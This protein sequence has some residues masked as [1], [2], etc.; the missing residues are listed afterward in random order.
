MKKIKYLTLGIC[1]AVVCS[2]STKA[3]TGSI[4]GAG[5]GAVIGGILGNIIGKD[6]KATVIGAAIGSAVGAGSG[7]LIGKHMD[8]VAAETAAQVENA[9]VET[10][11]DANGLS[12]VK[13]TFDSGILFKT[14]KYD[15]NDA[16]KNELANFAEVL[17]KNTDC[18]VDIQ[19]YTDNVGSDAV[20][21]PL[22]Q[23]R[24]ESVASYLKQKGVS[25]DQLKNVTGFGASN[26]V[27]DNSTEAG[28]QQNRR[29]EVYMYASE[30]MINAANSGTLR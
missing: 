5:G 4:I 3:G 15:L 18:S 22:S 21:N 20:N 11:T 12:C 27:A 16:S 26:F 2:C 14:G 17:K 28:R 30:A 25:N 23:N 29:V 9:K 6:S 8:K 24:A 13:V 10:V 7:A 19:G 1:V